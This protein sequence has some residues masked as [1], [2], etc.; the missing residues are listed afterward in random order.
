MIA[1]FHLFE[2][3]DLVSRDGLPTESAKHD[4][5]NAAS[6]LIEKASAVQR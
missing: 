1:F 6:T 4:R 3:F 2:V 5:S